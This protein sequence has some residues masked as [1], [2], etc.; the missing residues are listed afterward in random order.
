MLPRSP[1]EAH[2]S[3]TP[4]ELFFDLVIVVAVAQA[5]VA[6]HHGIAEGHF[7]DAV[8]SYAMVF[9][10]I[11]WAW[12]LFT[13]FAATYDI[14]D[15]PYRLIIFVQMTGALILA[16]GI[17]PA[18]NQHN[19]T[20]PTLGYVVMRLASTIHWVR[21]AIADTAHRPADIR[22]AVGTVLVQ[23][24]WVGL[25]FIPDGLK[26]PGFWLLALAEILIPIWAERPSPTPWH[27][28]HI[29]ERY[30]LF[31]LLV[32]G[33]SVLSISVAIQSVTEGGVMSNSLIGI[34]VGSLLIIYSLWWL[35][36]YQPIH[37]LMNTLRA[38]FVWAYWH[39]FIFGAVGAIGAGLEVV[40]DQGTGHGEIG[41]VAAGMAVALPCAIYVISLWV[42]HQ[43]TRAENPLDLLAHP[44]TA[45][46]ILLTPFTG[47]PVLLTGVLLASLVAVR[48]V[49]HLA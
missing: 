37:D 30:G 5:A 44:V 28:H 38:A 8:M 15:V 13:W 34:I 2:R 4:L 41:M 9:F 33:E 49:R 29:Q 12:M 26:L 14:D 3:A 18:F 32:L 39:W 35:Y 40:I 1:T 16:S 47:Q 19:L 11:W 24:A 10:A 31:T 42:L 46:L 23:A 20:I 36:F 45:V 6:L 27:L 22:Y 7:A 48:L 17:E 21:A 43:H 25:L